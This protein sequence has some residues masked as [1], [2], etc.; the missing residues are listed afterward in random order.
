MQL[1]AKQQQ[2]AQI[3]VLVQRA[4]EALML[5]PMLQWECGP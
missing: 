1:E 4:L 3:Q 5:D 2:V